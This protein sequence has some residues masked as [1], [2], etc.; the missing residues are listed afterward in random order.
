MSPSHS[1]FATDPMAD[2]LISR[3]PRY[4]ARPQPLESDFES[5][6]EVVSSPIWIT[7]AP[8]SVSCP[9]AASA[10]PICV[11]ELLSPFRTEHG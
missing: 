11:A 10:T 2:G 6:V 9:A 7:F 1:I 3:S 8:V 4:V 5:T